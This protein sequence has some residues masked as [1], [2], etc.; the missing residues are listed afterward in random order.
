MKRHEQSD[1]YV[2]AFG[3][4]VLHSDDHNLCLYAQW[5]WEWEEAGKG[6][7]EV[8]GSVPWDK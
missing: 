8:G 1:V 7:W 3:F 5:Q 2:K 4:H 6:G